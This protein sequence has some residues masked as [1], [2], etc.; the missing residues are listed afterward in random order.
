[1]GGGARRTRTGAHSPSGPGRHGSEG[2]ARACLGGQEW[3]SRGQLC[4]VPSQGDHSYQVQSHQD[5]G[6]PIALNC[7]EDD[8]FSRAF[9]PHADLCIYANH[10]SL[11]PGSCL[12]L[13]PRELGCPGPLQTLFPSGRWESDSPAWVPAWLSVTDPS[14]AE[15]GRK[16]LF[17]RLNPVYRRAV[18]VS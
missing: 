11:T 17:T 15:E 2:P 12:S 16:K 1:M 18:P 9:R 7:P 4:S 10:S 3:P 14:L 5:R 8:N 6:D 13:V